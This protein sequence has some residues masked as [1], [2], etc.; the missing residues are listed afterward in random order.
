MCD[1]SILASST[2]HDTVQSL[3]CAKKTE[4]RGGDFK[5]SVFVKRQLLKGG[6]VQWL[7]H[8]K[9]LRWRDSRW[10]PHHAYGRGWKILTYT[11]SQR[12]SGELFE[13]L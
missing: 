8:G 12:G 2:K 6:G 4:V 1:I 10:A 5:V 3:H 9:S 13:A 7:I 11:G